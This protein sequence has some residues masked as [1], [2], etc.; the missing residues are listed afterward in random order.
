MTTARQPDRVMVLGVGNAW[1]REQFGPLLID[2]SE[3]SLNTTTFSQFGRGR[4]AL[5]TADYQQLTGGDPRAL[6]ACAVMALDDPP[7]GVM[8]QTL[9]QQRELQFLRRGSGF[10]RSAGCGRARLGFRHRRFRRRL[11]LRGCL[12]IP[13]GSC[14][15]A[16]NRSALGQLIADLCQDLDYRTGRSGGNFHGRLV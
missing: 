4:L 9:T 16:N 15:D 3:A 12:T 7:T 1:R 11:G 8:N 13:R 14:L 10:R 6:D 2:W 5:A